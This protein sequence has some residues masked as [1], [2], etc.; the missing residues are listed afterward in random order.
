MYSGPLKS[1]TSAQGLDRLTHM[2]KS[3]SASTADDAVLTQEVIREALAKNP[4]LGEMLTRLAPPVAGGYYPDSDTMRLGTPNPDIAAHELG[5]AL[6]IRKTQIY[7]KL[8]KLTGDL[9][10]VNKTLAVPAML[11]IR[12]LV[13]SPEARRELFNTLSSLSAMAAAPGLA[14]ELSATLS[15]VQNS[16]DKART[17]Q[18]LIPAFLAHV[19]SSAAPIAVYQAGKV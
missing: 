15:A 19:A 7:G 6:N 2:G 8:L 10:R 4:E 17:L 18:L 9:V 13:S 11:T 5:H 14:E 1:L 12:A 16:K 3:E